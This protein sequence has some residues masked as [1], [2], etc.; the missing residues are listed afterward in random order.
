MVILK[1]EEIKNALKAF[2][3]GKDRTWELRILNTDKG[4]ISG[5]F[6]D[7]D[8]L[9]QLATYYNSCSNNVYVT[10]NPAY[11]AL[12]ARGKNKA[13]PYAKQTT[14]D[15]EIMMIY[16]LPIDL[17]PV[18]PSGI[19]STDDEHKLALEKAKEVRIFLEEHGFTAPIFADSGNGFHL[20]YPVEMENNPKSVKLIKGVLTTLDKLFSDEKVSIDTSVYNPARIWRLYGTKNCK[21]ED[22]KERPHRYSKLLSVP[23]TWDCVSEKKL[24]K[25]ASL[26]SDRSQARGQSSNHSNFDLKSWLEKNDMSIHYERSWGDGMLYKLDECPWRSEHTDKSAYVIQFNDGKLSAGCHHDSCQ[27][28]SWRTLRAKFDPYWK[29]ENSEYTDEEKKSQAEI[30]GEIAQQAKYLTSDTDDIYAVIN[31]ESH[32]EVYKVRGR[33]YRLWLLNKFYAHTGGIPKKETV[34]QVIDMVEAWADFGGEN[35]NLHL[36]VAE[37]DGKFYYDLS[38]G[39]RQIVEISQEGCQVLDNPPPLFYRTANMTSQVSPNFDGDINLLFKHIKLK[40]KEDQILLLTYILSSLV[41]NIPHVVLVLSGEKGAAKSTTLRMLRSIID[42]AKRDLLTMP[43]GYQDLVLVLGNNYMPCFDNLQMLTTDISDLLCVA[44][45]GGSVSKRKLYTDDEEVII[46]IRRCIGLNGINTV[47]AKEDLTD[48]SLFIKLERILKK[49]RKEEREIWEDFNRDKPEI[50]GGLLSTL[51]KA[52]KIYPDIKLEELSRMADF[53]RWGYAIA[54]ALGYDGE[55]FIEAYHNNQTMANEEALSNNP[56]SS[57]ILALMKTEQKWEGSV[58]QFYDALNFVAGKER[59]NTRV[60]YWPKAPHALSRRLNEFK[61][62]LAEWGIFFEIR[63][64]GE[65]KVITLTNDRP[66]QANDIAI[67]QTDLGSLDEFDFDD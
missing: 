36:R 56:I 58:T 31:M 2:S 38:N 48:R 43:R 59:I 11:D 25:V 4:T 40:E 55:E 32:N 33:K 39:T 7:D 42:P 26:Y 15:G 19:S 46:E 34:N 6:N 44:S 10:F 51:A 63:N 20:L 9:S 17:D 41:P 27:G 61:S 21:G 66:I 50:V 8:K 49:D 16:W 54:Q 24:E 23:E 62:N 52:M 5:Y 60:R 35:Q 28:E 64:T 67:D 29:S 57:A 30:M 13:N 3:R 12:L 65:N 18:R 53:T 47:V 1:E 22:T 14:K 45:T 37:K